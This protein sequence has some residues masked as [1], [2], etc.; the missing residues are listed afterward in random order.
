MYILFGI[1][2]TIFI[3]YNVEMGVYLQTVC[4]YLCF[5]RILDFAEHIYIYVYIIRC[6]ADFTAICVILYIFSFPLTF[7]H[8]R[9][10]RKN[11]SR[12]ATF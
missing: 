5:V 3:Q 8:V 11:V 9:N 7:F 6:I 12:A 1:F 10:P 4:I 2:V